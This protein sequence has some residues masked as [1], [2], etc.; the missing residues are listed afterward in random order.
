M[1]DL[2]QRH[3]RQFCAGLMT[4]G[5]ITLS[6]H[7]NTAQQINSQK[8]SQPKNARYC[9]LSKPRIEGDFPTHAYPTELNLELKVGAQVMFIKNDISPRKTLLQR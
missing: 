6:T 5:Y 9:I 4:E 8:L 1:A 2:N 7:N 3:I